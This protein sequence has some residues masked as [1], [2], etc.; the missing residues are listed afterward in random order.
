MEQSETE[1]IIRITDHGQ[2]IHS[3]HIGKIFEKFYRIGGADGRKP[4]TGLGLSIC[5]GFVE[6]MSGTI[7]AESPVDKRQG[8]RITVRLPL[9]LHLH[10][11]S[12][13]V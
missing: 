11:G 10:E 2:G 5:K 9:A 7:T 4:G 6:A 12:K 13:L 3:D 8:T 1:A